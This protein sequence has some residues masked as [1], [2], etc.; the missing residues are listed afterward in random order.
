MRRERTRAH[1]VLHAL[2]ISALP[3]TSLS[4]PA[5]F[6]INPLSHKQPRSSSAGSLDALQ[7]EITH[8]R[9][10]VRE[11]EQATRQLQLLSPDHCRHPLAAGSQGTQNNEEDI[12]DDGRNSWFSCVHVDHSVRKA[13]RILCMIL[14][15]QA[16]KDLALKIKVRGKN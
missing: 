11:L 1:A 4:R 9:A 2:L 8:L 3:S 13:P 15:T 7:R 5:R 6:N 12:D 10:K 14:S 16:E